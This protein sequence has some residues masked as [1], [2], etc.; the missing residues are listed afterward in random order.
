MRLIHWHDRE[1]LGIT[2]KQIESPFFA[3][4]DVRSAFEGRSFSTISGLDVRT[5]GRAWGQ[6]EILDAVESGHLLLVTNA[7]FSPLS[8]DTSGKY[9]FI[10][11]KGWAGRFHKRRSTEP[12]PLPVSKPMRTS[13]QPQEPGFY[14]VPES[15]TADAL[16]K[17]LFQSPS[18]AVL[19]KF[20]SLN[21]NLSEVK[22]GSMIV[23]SDPNNFQCT[24]EES[25][26]MEAAAHTNES[27]APLS[28]DEANFMMRHR[29]EIQSFLAL[30]STAIGVGE[31]M[32][33]RN[34]DDLKNVL[35]EIEALHQRAF[36]KDGHLRSPEFFSERKR[37]LA[38]LDTHLTSF[39]RKGT[40][41][42]DHPN[43]KFALGISSRSLVHRWTQAGTPGQIPG[44]ATH[45]KGISRAAKAIK[46]GGW[47][48]MAVGASALKVQ[49]V[50]S[51]GNKGACEKGKYTETGSYIGTVAG[52]AAAGAF[53]TGSVVSA[54]CVALGVPT[55]GAATLAC[56]IVVVGAGSFAGGTVVGTASEKFGEV[57]YEKTK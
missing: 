40:G 37:L 34:L 22:A 14:V 19:D 5:F 1:R 17:T 38:Q 54:L 48:G 13:P 3:A 53:L 44:Y 20:Q 57:I 46:Y 21:P 10:T 52:G 9:S 42:P 4:S 23:L 50:C 43:L 26:L 45:I 41:L 39:V 47:I 30:G 8:N 12:A 33:A 18:P 32:F 6:Q 51:A 56:G 25:R 7:P 2:F 35:Q 49:N 24:R 15:T 28:A 31:A 36:L 16:K 29:E 55:V 11:D 27:L